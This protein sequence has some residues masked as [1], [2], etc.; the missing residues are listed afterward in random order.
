[1]NYKP[2]MLRKNIRDIRANL[3]RGLYGEIKDKLEKEIAAQ[4]LIMAELLAKKMEIFQ[5]SIRAKQAETRV[6]KF[7]Q[8]LADSAA[9]AD[10]LARKPDQSAKRPG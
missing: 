4:K 10:E 7:R 9:R 2:K 1:M 6:A 3:E 8:M 5:V